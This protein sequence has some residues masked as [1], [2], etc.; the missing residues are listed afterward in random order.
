MGGRECTEAKL[1]GVVPAMVVIDDCQRGAGVEGL[2]PISHRSQPLAPSR[3]KGVAQAVNNG[4]WLARSC[5]CP[6]STCGV[7][8]GHC[9]NFT[10]SC[11]R[12]LNLPH[13]EAAK[14]LRRWGYESP[15]GFARNAEPSECF[16]L[17]SSALDKSGDSTRSQHETGLC[18]VDPSHPDAM[19]IVP[20]EVS[21]SQGL[22]SGT[23]CD[24]GLSFMVASALE[25][26]SVLG[27]GES[28]LSIP[29]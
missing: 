17:H 15:A 8:E 7:G 22:P 14:H 19:L 10:A 3:L 26:S 13:Q 9:T 21:V 2:E 27:R 5:R 4:L 18:R 29:Y 24:L 23:L 20:L 28:W 6:N 16:T 11:T 12:I 25:I 1:P